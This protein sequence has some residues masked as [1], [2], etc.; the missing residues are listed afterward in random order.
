MGAAA[1]V[2]RPRPQ[3][4]ALPQRFYRTWS[5][6]LQGPP[7]IT[8]L[9]FHSEYDCAKETS[10]TP[11]L[12]FRL[13]RPVYSI[14]TEELLEKGDGDTYLLS[15]FSQWFISSAGLLVQGNHDR[16]YCI[17]PSLTSGNLFVWFG[18]GQCGLEEDRWFYLGEEVNGKVVSKIDSYS[19]L[20]RYFISLL[21]QTEGPDIVEKLSPIVKDLFNKMGGGLEAAL[22]TSIDQ[23]ICN[24]LALM[25]ADALFVAPNIPLSADAPRRLGA[26]VG[27]AM[28]HTAL[29]HW[30]QFSLNQSRR[31]DIIFAKDQA[32]R[33]KAGLHYSQEIAALSASGES[34][35]SLWRNGIAHYAEAELK[36]KL[37]EALRINDKLSSEDE[38]RNKLAKAWPIKKDVLVATF[39]VNYPMYLPVQIEIFARAKMFK[40]LQLHNCWQRHPRS[41]YT[42]L[43]IA[44]FK[45]ILLKLGLRNAYQGTP[46]ICS[47]P[48]SDDADDDDNDFNGCNSQ[49]GSDLSNDYT[50]N[51]DLY[52][53][54]PDNEGF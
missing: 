6:A 47:K 10:V 52:R 54:I 1:S 17:A 28:K 18:T 19:A 49:R 34:F 13:R 9:T 8:Q 24:H 36:A 33:I 48:S 30:Y 12:Y 44:G 27:I 25:S 3:L 7:P 32:Q 16:G 39:I 38:I 22:V 11:E 51:G 26:W 35:V 40:R 21:K 20:L 37:L 46:S 53:G 15:R 4:V 14:P 5:R 31:S 50:D 43:R 2:T 45:A 29:N 41:Y 23:I 42:P